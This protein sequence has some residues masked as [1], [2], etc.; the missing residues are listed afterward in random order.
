M[1]ALLLVCLTLALGGC[2]FSIYQL[3]RRPEE[4]PLA[5]PVLINRP[6][7]LHHEAAGFEFSEQYGSF[8]RVTAYRYDVEGLHASFGYNDRS[9]GCLVV[10]T[11]YVY[12]T[13]RLTVL[14]SPPEV[15][16]SA[17]RTFLEREFERSKQE[18][19]RS[20]PTMHTLETSDASTPSAGAALRG[21]RLRF[22]EADSASEL[23]L[24]VY[25]SPA[26]FLKYRFTYPEACAPEA[27]RR[28]TALVA[29]LPWATQS[30]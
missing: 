2:P 20:H 23:R 11:F 8:Q 30:P 1:R 12:P 28:L 19:E 16:A 7:P 25:G 18:L 29:Q 26:W 17:Y 22:H 27:E 13:P 4:Q 10:A 24:F 5:E 9:D 14:G 21:T 6:G 3:D 15:V